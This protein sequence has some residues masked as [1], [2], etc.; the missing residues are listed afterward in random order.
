MH[1]G[2]SP[3]AVK[4]NKKGIPYALE[5]PEKPTEA[6]VFNELQ[7][8]EDFINKKHKEFS[9]NQLL[10][11]TLKFYSEVYC[12]YTGTKPIVF[13]DFNIT[14]VFCGRA[15]I[16]TSDFN[17]RFYQGVLDGEMGVCTIK[18]GYFHTL[19]KNANIECYDISIHF[20]D[21]TTSHN[22]VIYKPTKNSGDWYVL[23]C[24]FRIIM[25]D[26]KATPLDKLTIG[27]Y[28]NSIREGYILD[29]LVIDP[30]ISGQQSPGVDLQ[31]EIDIFLNA[32]A[33][34]D[35]LILCYNET[36]NLK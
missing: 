11:N 30:P 26:G 23:P 31:S 5:L 24:G 4:Y 34:I 22:F 32:S 10:N 36:F 25:E 13:K 9:K 14:N 7:I 15:R 16:N 19:L 3:R 17:E 28:L 2:V 35:G 21:G 8:V 27:Y 12:T 20:L 6:Q 33:E 18:Q 1:R 29:Y